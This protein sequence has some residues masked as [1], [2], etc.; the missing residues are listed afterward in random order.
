MGG[1]SQPETPTSSYIEQIKDLSIQSSNYLSSKIRDI[2]Y[3][4]LK[5]EINELILALNQVCES[6]ERES[7]NNYFSKGLA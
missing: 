3:N 7:N 4:D 1:M 2:L 6:D 5:K